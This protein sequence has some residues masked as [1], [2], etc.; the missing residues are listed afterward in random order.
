[1]SCLFEAVRNDDAE[2]LKRL[3]QDGQP[4]EDLQGALCNAAESGRLNLV[5]ILTRHGVRDDWAVVGAASFADVQTVRFLARLG[6]NI[7]AAFIG[8]AAHGRLENLRCL[9]A[10]SPTV[11]DEALADAALRGFFDVAR[12]LLDGGANPD[13]VVYGGK[14]AAGIAKEKGDAALMRLFADFKKSG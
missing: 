10:F 13:A 8:A 3:L 12:F 1:M 7:D 11:S 14:T 9:A 5:E 6:G 2:L 4:L